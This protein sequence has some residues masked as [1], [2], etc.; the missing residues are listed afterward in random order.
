MHCG[1]HL[2]LR[3]HHWLF[4]EDNSLVAVSVHHLRGRLIE[5]HVVALL[6]DSVWLALVVWDQTREQVIIHHVVPH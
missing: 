3:V 4:A 6:V 5:R 1:E 2:S